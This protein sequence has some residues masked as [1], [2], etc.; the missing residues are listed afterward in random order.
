[1]DSTEKSY[2]V[3]AKDHIKIQEEK[4]KDNWHYILYLVDCEFI[5]SNDEDETN[6]SNSFYA[7]KLSLEYGNL[8]TDDSPIDLVDNIESYLMDKENNIPIFTFI[9]GEEMPYLITDTPQIE[10]WSANNWKEIGR[11]YDEKDL[12]KFFSSIKKI[13]Y[14]FIP[15]KY[16]ENQD[17]CFISDEFKI[18]EILEEKYTESLINKQ[19]YYSEILNNKI[20]EELYKK[21]LFQEG[22][23]IIKLVLNKYPNNPY[24]LDTLADGYYHLNEYELALIASDKC[25]EFDQQYKL[26]KAEH[27]ENRGKI[28]I[29]LNKIEEANEDL[30]KAKKIIEIKETVDKLIE[31]YKDKPFDFENN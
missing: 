22:V 27:Y 17:L 16:F 18:T 14:N 1:M 21:G 9:E 29:K 24:Y 12:F 10:D 15:E 25:I 2:I 31:M 3:L 4:N 6:D 28:K 30:N 26:N 20:Y 23:D 19:D 7:Y 8:E 5:I 13:K 11:F